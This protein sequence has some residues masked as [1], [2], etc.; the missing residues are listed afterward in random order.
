MS[1]ACHDL[2]HLMATRLR[3]PMLTTGLHKLLEA[4]DNFVRAAAHPPKE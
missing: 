3:G 2:A 4:K 1:A